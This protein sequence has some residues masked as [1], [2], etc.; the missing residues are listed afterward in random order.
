MRRSPS[1]FLHYPNDPA[2]RKARRR[3]LIANYVGFSATVALSLVALVNVVSPPFG[4]ALLTVA[5]VSVTAAVAWRLYYIHSREYPAGHC[6]TCGYDLR[7]SNDRCPECGTRIKVRGAA[8]GGQAR[9]L[10]SNRSTR[11]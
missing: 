11:D 1:I 9:P 7:A 3:S 5:W 6:G 4:Y 8:N 2:G 10:N